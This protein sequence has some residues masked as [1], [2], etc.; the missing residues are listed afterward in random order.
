MAYSRMDT[1][2]HWST[3]WCTPDPKVVEGRDTALFRV[4]PHI[5]FTAK[6]L[7][8]DLDACIA[9]ADTLSP[10]GNL[11]DLKAYANEFLAEVDEDY[12]E[13]TGE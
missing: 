7:R 8:D 6:E 12:P 3:F 10:G 1:K 4:W 11:S 5:N 9:K 13:E 2:E